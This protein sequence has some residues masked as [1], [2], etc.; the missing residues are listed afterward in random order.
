MATLLKSRP[1]VE[2]LLPREIIPGQEVSAV[3][4]LRCR[5]SIS[6]DAIHV[7]FTGTERWGE[8]QKRFLALVAELGGQDLPEGETRLP[9]RFAI[10]NGN[11]P[12]YAGTAA[13]VR[14]EASVHV[15]IPWWPD[16]RAQFTIFVGSTPRT[17]PVDA[18]QRYS[19]RP[20]GPAGK[21]A[22]AE[23]SLTSQ[24]A[25]PG[26]II[27]GAFALSNT[28]YNR[29]GAA[30]L[31]LNSKESS[32]FGFRQSMA[33]RS[34][35]SRIEDTSQGEATMIPFRMSLPGTTTP[36]FDE[37]RPGNEVG[38]FSVKWEFVLEVEVRRGKN[39]V[40]AIPFDVLPIDL[41]AKT[42]PY[43]APPVV[44][45]NRTGEL[46]KSVGQGH[47]FEMHGDEL[48][49]TLG[50]SSV[51]IRREHQG[52]DGVFLLAS[53]DFPSLDLGLEVERAG[54]LRRVMGGGVSFD[55]PTFDTDYF[56]RARDTE[57]T[58]ASLSD[59]FC[60]KDSSLTTRSAR[61][62]SMDDETCVM[63][64]ADNG[65]SEEML[66]TIL[67]DANKALGTL[68]GLAAKVEPPTGLSGTLGEW[69][70]LR[71]GLGAALAIGSLRVSGDQGS[72]SVEVVTLFGKDGR[73]DATQLRVMPSSPLDVAPFEFNADS[74]DDA[75]VTT[76]AG[77]I[78]QRLSAALA[79]AAH[80]R[81][82]KDELVLEFD[83]P[84]GHPPE[85]NK[86]LLGDAEDLD[87]ASALLRI[88]H[89]VRVVGLLGGESG[90]YR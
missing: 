82:D 74:P 57:Q 86:A 10:P 9:F 76:F 44:G 42:R 65:H 18:P 50:E 24:W 66:S 56:V 28:A 47:G 67:E 78:A 64:L 27:S 32:H 5:K 41:T 68:H 35:A 36:G 79:G 89:L 40:M 6:V 83:A 20:S 51:V 2:L 73:P 12:T 62:Q 48:R 14:Y 70:F 17:S 71:D 88:G 29:Y 85:A 77:E 59:V 13:S 7:Q 25:R 61:L 75:L 11:P 52:A 22:H 87:A 33:A 3:L 55:H 69:E 43:Q 49:K 39:I 16:R 19:T 30:I 53:F 54:T 63:S 31:R 15:D 4:V 72:V 21:E 84:L 80:F 37:H 81:M 58:R 60:A 8:V 38:L 46:W 1:D 90:P 26:D 23:L 45:S 34:F